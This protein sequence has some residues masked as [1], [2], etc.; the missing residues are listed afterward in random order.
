MEGYDSALEEI[1]RTGIKKP[2]RTGVGCISVAGLQ[3]KYRL[4]TEYFPIVTGRKMFPKAVWA[5]LLWMLS[6]STNNQDLE[7]LGAKFWGKW[8][9]ESN[10]KYVE[11]RAKWGLLPGDFGAI[12]GFQLRHYGAYYLEVTKLRNEIK[13]LD[14]KINRQQK[15]EEGWI[16]HPDFDH[17]CVLPS[18]S[19]IFQRM[20]LRNGLHHEL[21]NGVDQL[22]YMMDIL[23]ND[24]FGSGGRRCLWSLWNPCDLDKMALPPCHY[25]YQAIPDGDGGLTGIL[26]QRS[27]DFPVGVPANIQFYSALT[28]MLAQQSGLKPREFVHNTNDCHIYLNQVEQ[29]EEYLSRP[30]PDSPKL[31]IN[32]APDIY[33]YKVDDFVVSDYHP[34]E[35]IEMPV[36]V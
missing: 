22:A 5:E 32:K 7:A 1:L 17:Q 30:K 20:N 9:D 31:T 25:T 23:Q 24:P 21:G 14:E 34:L 13:A 29:V 3:R 2:D 6:G 18:S 35:K 36:A 12:Y 15:A 28:I 19:M 26:G 10:P 16:D 4:D 8:C 11:F 33:S 27:C